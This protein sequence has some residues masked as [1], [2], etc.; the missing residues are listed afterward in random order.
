MAIA[1]EGLTLEE[2]LA[3]PDEKPA[4]EYVDGTIRQKVA[5]L[6]EHSVLQRQLTLGWESWL[7]PRRLGHAF[8]ELRVSFGGQSHVPDVSVYRRERLPRRARGQRV[9]ELHLPPDLV[10]EIRSPGQTH[11]DLAALGTWYV[12]HG[13]RIALLVDDRDE[14]VWVYRPGAAPVVL[15]RG[16]TL[17]LDE[18]APG[19]QL[20][21]ADLFGALEEN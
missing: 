8:P 15:R 20:L 2:F 10:V 4:L 3:L 11:A 14:S 19:L 12:D 16:A 13:V 6:Y 5:P 21:L 1:R 18:I 9:G 7:A 17:D